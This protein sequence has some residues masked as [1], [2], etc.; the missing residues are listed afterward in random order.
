MDRVQFA[1]GDVSVNLGSGNTSVAEQELDGAQVRAVA[2]EI[3][4]KTVAQS[5]R[6]N[7]F[8]NSR[9]DRVTSDKS[10]DT[11]WRQ[12]FF[13]L[14]NKQWFNHVLTLIQIYF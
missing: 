8:H 10:L 2:Q 6:G 14:T 12:P 1:V 7:R 4:G 11:A 13:L 3:G 5:M 9:R